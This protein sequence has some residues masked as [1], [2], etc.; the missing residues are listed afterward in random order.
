MGYTHEMDKRRVLPRG[1]GMKAAAYLTPATIVEPLT[2]M[3]I[4][5]L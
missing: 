5:L 1:A 2:S 3:K 4:G